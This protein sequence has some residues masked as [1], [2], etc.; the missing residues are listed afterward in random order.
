MLNIQSWFYDNFIKPIYQSVNA[1][2]FVSHFKF[3]INE[4]TQSVKVSV[5][6][7]NAVKVSQK[8][9]KMES[10]ED[11]KIKCVKCVKMQMIISASIAFLYLYYS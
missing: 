11:I 6:G 9:V 3:V 8:C 5:D 10:V 2:L 4:I 7:T 1:Q